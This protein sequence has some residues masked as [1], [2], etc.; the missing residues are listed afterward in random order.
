MLEKHLETGIEA[1]ALKIVW[2]LGLNGDAII[3]NPVTE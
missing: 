3:A 1:E 2:D